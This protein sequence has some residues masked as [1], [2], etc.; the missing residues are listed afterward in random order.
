MSVESNASWL[1]KEGAKSFLRV[2]ASL[3]GKT[4]ST[5]GSALG[6]KALG[7]M[8][9]ADLQFISQYRKRLGYKEFASKKELEEYFLGLPNLVMEFDG[10]V[11]ELLFEKGTKK[12]LESWRSGTSGGDDQNG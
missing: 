9:K 3:D 10:T 7:K 4:V 2:L 12:E 6:L 11:T 8:T 5:I 1:M